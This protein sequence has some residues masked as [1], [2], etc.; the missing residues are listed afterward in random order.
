MTSYLAVIDLLDASK[1]T[2]TN[3][4][5]QYILLVFLAIA[6]LGYF[7]W[8]R[9]QQKKAAAARAGVS[10]GMEVGDQVQTIGGVI[11]TILEIHGD[12]YTLLTGLLNEDG[13]LDGPQP[14]RIV[15]VR[16]A[17]A[18][19][20]EPLVPA[21][22]DLGADVTSIGEAPDADLDDHEDHEDTDRGAAEG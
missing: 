20:I 7:F 19:K 16:Q 8:L 14:T 22:P 9:P 15:F 21:D 12:R 18:R 11:G 2:T 4:G 5:S 13:N 10:S 1:K 6:V 17:I 3:S